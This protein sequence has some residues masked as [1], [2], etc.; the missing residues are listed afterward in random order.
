MTIR[1]T[2]KV[3]ARILVALVILFGILAAAL[4]IPAVQTFAVSKAMDRLCKNLDCDMQVE[5]VIFQPINTLILK[6]VV[7]LDNSPYE[8]DLDVPQDTVARIGSVVARF[9]FKS[10]VSDNGISLSRAEVH[11]GVFNMVSEPD[12]DGKT[13]NIKRVFKI[14]PK[15]EKKEAKTKIAV[16]RVVVD[17]MDIRLLSYTAKRSNSDHGIKWYDFKG[18]ANVEARNIKF[19]EGVI[20]GKVDHCDIYEK[21]GYRIDDLKGSFEIGKGIIDLDDLT[22]KDRWSDVHLPCLK[23]TLD[24]KKAFRDYA[25]RVRFDGSFE[26]SVLSFT[27]LSYFA[28]AL[29]GNPIV[30]NIKSGTVSGP[31]I[32][33]DITNLVFTDTNSGVNAAA[34]VRL[35]GLPQY[36][37]LELD[38]KFKELNFSTGGLGSF[39]SSFMKGKELDL[40]RF[41]SGESFSFNGIVKGPISHFDVDGKIKSTVGDLTADVCIKNLST[42]SP[43]DIHGKTTTTNVDIGKIIGKDFVHD[44]SLTTGMTATLSKGG[45]KL[46]IDSLIVNKLNLHGYDYSNIRAA[47]NYSGNAFDGRIIC[48]DPNLNFMFQGL[49]N[50]SRKTNNADYR[51]FAYL[52]YADLHA[53]NFDSR[54]LSRVSIGSINANYTR[55]K[56]GDLLGTVDV[57][58]I[59][60]ESSA[61]R[62]NVGN[63]HMDSRNTD[64]RS[65]MTIRS[66]FVDGVYSG[67]K[68]IS[69]FVKD[70][71]DITVKRELP[72]LF[73]DK[74]QKLD[75]SNYDLRLDFHDSRNLLSFIAPGT[76]IADS[77]TVR[78]RVD[79]DGILNGGIR[80]QRIA[81]KNKYIKGIDLTLNNNDGALNASLKGDKIS[82]SKKLKLWNNALV[83]YAN[84]NNIGLG[85]NYNNLTETD[86]RGELYI[87]GDLSQSK[88]GDIDL[89][90][91][92]L[93]SNLYYNGENWKFSPSEFRYNKDGIQ[94][95]GL[96]ISNDNQHI[97]IKGG[98]SSDRT[99]TLSVNISNLD[100][101]LIDDLTAKD[102]DI[103]GIASGRVLLTS[104]TKDNLGL[105]VN[106]LS[107][108]TSINGHD[109]GQIRIGSNWDDTE[110]KLNLVVRNDIAGKSTIDAKGSYSP[111]N[112]AIAANASLNGFDLGYAGPFIA[113]VFDEFEGKLK[114]SIDVNGSLDHIDVKGKGLYIDDGRLTVGYTKVPYTLSG[115]LSLDTRGVHF[116]NIAIKDRYNGSGVLSGGIAFDHFKDIKMDTHI[117]LDNVEC[118]NTGAADNSTFF[119]HVFGTGRMSIT[120]PFNALLLD[121]DANTVRDGRFSIP[122]G[123]SGSNK[124]KQ[125][126]TF[127]E[128][129]RY[130]YIDPYE[131]M[132]STLDEA[133]KKVNNM[134]VK[135]RIA[136][137][138]GV[139]A[140]LNMSGNAEVAM[141]GRG[142][143][144]ISIEVKPATDV[145]TI[146][147][148]YTLNSG[149]C[150]V[151]AFGIANK[152]F[153]I[154]NGSSIKFNGDIMDSDLNLDANYQIKTSLSNLIS[155]TTSVS[156]RRIVDCG[157]NISDKLKNPKLA[158]SIDIPDLDP[159]T[160]SRV[161]SAL[162][163]DDKVQK[164]FMALLVTNNFIPDEQS[165]VVNNSNILYSNVADIMVNQ[166]NSILQKLEIPLDLDMN[167]Q[168]S[169]SGTSIFDVALSTQL[170]NN[171][172][173][174][175]GNIGNRQYLSS[176]DDDVVGDLDIEIKM[177]KSGQV[178]LNL[179][180]HSADQYT[181]YLDNSQ[182]NGVGVTYQK[183]F[184]TLKEFINRMF[185]SKEAR[186]QMD[187]EQQLSEKETV[188]IQIE[189]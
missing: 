84:D 168:S 18:N 86:N 93:T 146:N 17:N 138:N 152:D 177:D 187:I 182:R 6:N 88:P 15:E 162:S 89:I 47:G 1:K 186:Q 40:S 114:G 115:P 73:K 21:S 160:K 151:S 117:R 50:L 48:N 54:E 36:R 70:L 142:A 127:K 128:L 62:N 9:T 74:A 13:S 123:G 126:L 57:S 169:Q 102:L 69:A 96:S 68:T 180:S 153:S 35:K 130:V 46:S 42:K 65:S 26:P 11:D 120:G 100:L 156:S 139:E 148:D 60:L 147:G 132:M 155:D 85:F 157:I 56:K 173:V 137:H 63:V 33:L 175:N 109:A 159:S 176:N 34:D 97:T 185:M 37:D 59:I 149:N 111:K 58:D 87:T 23:L 76:Y 129:E 10:L 131:Q 5:K 133:Q 164:Q 41:A 118:L 171:R 31:I 83:L 143:G 64:E 125:L 167:Y 43:L 141:T 172:V 4:Q 174:V 107:T 189:K 170:F 145:F 67:S 7:L 24:G 188:T 121:I 80:S 116:E 19:S 78:L 95:D 25:T 91:K 135:V 79:K 98:V 3:I 124:S 51:F 150:H 140:A 49:F 45:T 184:N 30:A 165:G 104:P 72:A 119:G 113:S 71:Q 179:F 144:T 101:M 77:S 136:A 27:T 61:G 161:E 75:N 66:S 106:V 105:L 28:P 81:F 112:K 183:E 12:G 178:R 39:L 44:C 110:N 14:Q 20:S 90:A 99:D 122:L 108:G 158:F 154:L 166:L 82:I 163:T 94:V 2:C 134:V 32:D 181:N 22:I 52:G 38:G 92:S 55:I 53:L 29:K 8:G 103:K 16:K